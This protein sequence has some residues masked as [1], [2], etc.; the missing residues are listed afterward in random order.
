MEIVV[1]VFAS[2]RSFGA[3]DAVHEAQIK[4]ISSTTKKR[5]PARIPMFLE[6]ITTLIPLVLSAFSLHNLRK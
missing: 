5:Q 6:W 3:E 1:F 4:R 2:F